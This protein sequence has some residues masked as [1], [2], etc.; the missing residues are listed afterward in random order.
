MTWIAGLT[1]WATMHTPAA[2]DR[3][4][5]D[6]QAWLVFQHF[7]PFRGHSCDQQGFV[8]RMDITIAMNM[9]E[10]LTMQLGLIIGSAMK[11]HFR[12]HALHSGH[13]ARIGFFRNDNDGFDIE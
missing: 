4:Y 5:D 12:S 8:A 1:A 11:D 3:H 9:S 10:G 2:A 13:L 6:V 7:Q